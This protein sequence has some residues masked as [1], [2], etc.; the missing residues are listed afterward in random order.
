LVLRIRPSRHRA[1]K[2]ILTVALSLIVSTLAPALA[3][4]PAHGAPND[5]IDAKAAEAKRLE[6]AIQANGQRI[7]QLDE[8][9]NETRIRIEETTEGLAD[10]QARIERAQREADVLQGQLRGRAAVLYTQAGTGSPFPVL[11]ADSVRDLG[12]LSTYSDAA[13]ERD[14]N[15]IADLS[16]AR[17]LLD[18]RQD[19]LERARADAEARQS[20]LEEQRS[21]IEAA[22]AEQEELLSQVEGELA[23]LVREEQQRRERAAEQAARAAFAERIAREQAARQAAGSGS[24]DG[25]SGSG[26]APSIPAPNVPAPGGGA[27]TAIDTARAQL[28]KPYEYA[29]SGPDTFD[30]SGLTMF[31]WG[32]AGVSLPHSS[33][34]QYASLPHV[35]MEAMAPGDLVFY[36]S[37]I[38]HVGMYLGGGVYIHA[39]QT[40]DVVKISSVYRDDFAGAARPG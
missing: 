2:R 40:G 19:E 17:E 38:H 34:A 14:D 22:Q 27:Q 25:S 21:S 8:E 4:G 7:S 23:Q 12:A 32:A 3:G 33:R 10:A 28:G 6:A 20:Q 1:P 18:E 11:D 26:S 39:P 31:A 36:G 30:C 5:T 37:P 24:D 13:A 15:L 16:A 9:Y 29:A 35:P